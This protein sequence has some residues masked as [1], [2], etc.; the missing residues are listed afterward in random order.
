M[1]GHIKSGDV[2]VLG[3]ARL[4]EFKEGGMWHPE[5]MTFPEASIEGHKRK[6]DE[7]MMLNPIG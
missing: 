7:G 5:I 3:Q 6:R 4:A 1:R 2:T